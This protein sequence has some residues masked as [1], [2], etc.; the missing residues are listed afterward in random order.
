MVLRLTYEGKEFIGGRG[1]LE[2][3]QGNLQYFNHPE[4]D[5]F[6]E[7]EGEEEILENDVPV[8]F[9]RY[10]GNLLIPRT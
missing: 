4:G 9:H 6:D 1:S 10:H 5:E 2:F 3:R 8:G 7:F